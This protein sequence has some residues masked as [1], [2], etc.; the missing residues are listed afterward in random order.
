MQIDQDKLKAENISLAAAYREKS[1]KHQQTQE[2]YDRLKRKEMT[3]VTQSAAYDS[4]EDVIQSASNRQK[5]V[6]SGRAYGS[7]M[8]NGFRAHAPSDHFPPNG[9]ATEQRNRDNGSHGSG[10]SGQ[11]MPPSFHRP[12]QGGFRKYHSPH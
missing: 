2:L 5:N 4:V 6:T 10:V 1:K 9:V 7:P 3:A 11:M 8:K 12:A